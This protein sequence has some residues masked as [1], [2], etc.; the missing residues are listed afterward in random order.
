M[1]LSRGTTTFLIVWSGQLVS[2]VGSNLTSFAL[3][4][5]VYE[6]TDSATHYALIYLFTVLPQLLISPLAGA[7]IDRW[8]R[9]RAMLLSDSGAGLSTLAIL[10]LLLAG[11]LDVWHVYVAV[12]VSAAFGAFQWP[13]YSAAIT[14]L[15]PKQH[16]A[17]ASGLVDV[18]QG[19]AYLAGPALAGFLMAVSGLKSVI[20]IDF[21]TFGAAVLTLLAVRFPRPTRSAE[22]EAARGTLRRDLTFGWGYI[23]ARPGLLALLAFFAVINFLTGVLMALGTP[24]ILAFTSTATL[25]VMMSVGAFGGL[26]GSGIMGVWGGPARRINGVLGFGV[27]FGL[28][29]VAMGLRPSVILVTGAMTVLFC[30]LPVVNACSQAIW[31]SKV[32]ADVQGRVFAVRSMVSF[33]MLPLAYLLAGPLADGVFEP[34]LMPDGALASSVGQ[35]IG[36]GAGRGMGL[37]FM[38]MGVLVLLT[39]LAGYLYPRLR[40]L[41]DELPDQDHLGVVEPEAAPAAAR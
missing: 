41:E 29:C 1:K 27:I 16:Y 21:V 13:A 2:V 37:L 19:L 40:Q 6:R 31:Q 23:R 7:L 15:I 18:A 39:S 36:T 28:G 25:G 30:C 4:V 10:L 8:D 14:L 20:A 38:V 35:V 11:R 9:R 26:V 33:S 22:G 3:G 34:L 12:A 5:W 24:L 32:A 17:R